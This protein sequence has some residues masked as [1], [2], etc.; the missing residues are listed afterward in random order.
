MDLIEI[1]DLEGFDVK[2]WIV[3]FNKGNVNVFDNFY[4]M[5]IWF[6]DIKLIIVECRDEEKY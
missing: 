4:V 5:C 2:F 6:C 3:C 1:V